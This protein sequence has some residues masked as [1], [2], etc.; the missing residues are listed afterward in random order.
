MYRKG[1]NLLHPEAHN[2]RYQVF[3]FPRCSF[4]PSLLNS[5]SFFVMNE[6]EQVGLVSTQGASAVCM[7]GDETYVNQIEEK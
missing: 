1:N 2:N 4:R 3:G 7:S 6:T 5:P